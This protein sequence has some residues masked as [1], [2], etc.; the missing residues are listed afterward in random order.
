M[1][2]CQ[3]SRSH[4]LCGSKN[5]SSWATTLNVNSHTFMSLSLSPRGFT[6]HGRVKYNAGYTAESIHISNDLLSWRNGIYLGSRCLSLEFLRGG[7]TT[8]AVSSDI[9]RRPSAT[10]YEQAK[11]ASGTSVR[12]VECWRV[13]SWKNGPSW[14]TMELSPPIS[15]CWDH[16][17][18]VVR[19][20]VSK[21]MWEALSRDS[22][23][24]KNPKTLWS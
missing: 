5:W 16:Y 19:S 24:E 1:A 9:T 13:M 8:H 18:M 3:S 17:C 4:T 2:Q 21:L 10:L 15:T 20:K 12:V 23:H 6:K 11:S 14:L 22:C 7:Q